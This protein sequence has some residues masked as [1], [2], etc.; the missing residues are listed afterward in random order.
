MAEILQVVL[1]ELKGVSLPA[2]QL[3]SNTRKI[4][5][6]CNTCFC[7]KQKRFNSNAKVSEQYFEIDKAYAFI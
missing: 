7:S 6:S 1:D 2:S 3:I 4:K 5:V